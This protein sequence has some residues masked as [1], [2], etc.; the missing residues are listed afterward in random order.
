M[1][2]LEKLKRVR[3]QLKERLTLCKADYLEVI[4]EY[5]EALEVSLELVEREIVYEK[6]I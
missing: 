3:T 6:S 2:E 5:V 4:P 1:M